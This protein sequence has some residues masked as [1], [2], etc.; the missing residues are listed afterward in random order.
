[1]QDYR[2]SHKSEK[3]RRIWPCIDY[4]GILYMVGPILCQGEDVRAVSERTRLKES[5]LPLLLQDEAADVDPYIG[6][7]VDGRRH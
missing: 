1:M 2:S 3:R 7:H 5:T 6:R 4:F